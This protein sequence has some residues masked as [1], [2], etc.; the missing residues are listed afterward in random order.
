MAFRAQPQNPGYSKSI[1]MSS[2]ILFPNSKTFSS[3]WDQ[4]LTHLGHHSA[5]FRDEGSLEARR[6]SV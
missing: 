4:D 3:S 5:D 6:E 1:S 2:K